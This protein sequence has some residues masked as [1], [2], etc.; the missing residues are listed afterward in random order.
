MGGLDDN[1]IVLLTPREHFIAHLLLVKIY[2]TEHKLIYA[3]NMM[4]VGNG[5]KQTNRTYGWI[6]E[7]I[8]QNNKPMLGK[9]HTAETKQQMSKAQSKENNHFFGKTHT[10]ET[11]QKMKGPRGPNCAKGRPKTE[12]QRKKI[13]ETLKR[14][15]AEGTVINGMTGKTH[16]EETKQKMR[17]ARLKLSGLL[18]D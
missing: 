5:R 6:K 2:P 17:N 9:K 18:P 8:I 1:N 3:L 16:S 13:S 12:E 15:N 10:E 14:R 7:L 4:C 11:K